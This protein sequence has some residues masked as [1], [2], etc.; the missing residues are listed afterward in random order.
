MD[1][2]VVEEARVRARVKR[3]HMKPLKRR[4]RRKH[5]LWSEIGQGGLVGFFLFSLFFSFFFFWGGEGRVGTYTTNKEFDE[6][7]RRGET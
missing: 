1:T 4:F 6:F 2:R 7:I 5:N 3:V